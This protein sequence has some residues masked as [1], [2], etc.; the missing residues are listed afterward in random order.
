MKICIISLDFKPHRSSGL[1][2]YAEDLV[3]GLQEVGH[4]ITVIASQRPGLEVHHWFDN[5]EIYRVPSGP[6]DWISFGWNAA[7]MLRQIN[8]RSRFQ[9]V[10]FVDVH[11]AYAYKEHFL[12]SIWQ[13]FRQRLT[14]QNGWPYHTG[15]VDMVR[16]ELYY[17]FARRWMERPSV[18]RAARLISGCRS[19]QMEFIQYYKAS[20]ERVDLAFQGIDTDFFCP[21]PCEDL[22]RQLGLAGRRVI[23]FMGF[24]TPRKGLEYLAKALHLLPDDTVLLIAGKWAPH[25]RERFYRALG[26]GKNRVLELGYIPDEERPRY[27]S[28]ADVYVSPS[29]LEGFG[30]TP[31]EAMACGTPAVVTSASSGP[32]EVGDAGRVVPPCNE[33]LLASA[34]FELLDNE[35]LRENLGRIGR[36]RVLD[37]FSYRSMTESTILSYER[38]LSQSQGG[39]NG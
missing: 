1:S 11:F 29:I 2:Y 33:E 22:Q 10:H 38:F 34:L 6:L 14:A 17:R 8:A 35:A 5:I 7:G 28:L 21:V 39:V 20:P 9:V 23:F 15:F 18:E 12:A 26:S 25:V 37:Y 4:S 32:E 24:I 31:I 19:T 36:Q 30:I 3:R 13:S 27:Y 16:R